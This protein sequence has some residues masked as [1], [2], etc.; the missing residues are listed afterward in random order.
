MHQERLEREVNL[1]RASRKAGKRETRG[2]RRYSITLGWSNGRLGLAPRSRSLESLHDSNIVAESRSS[3]DHRP[4]EPGE[5]KGFKRLLVWQVG[6]DLVTECY[7]LSASF[8]A[9][10]QYGLTR[11]LP[12]SVTLNIAEGWGRDRKSELARGCEIARGSLHEVDAAF[13]VAIRLEY[14]SAETCNEAFRLVN[15]EGVMLHRL[16]ASLKAQR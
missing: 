1:V 7:R 11:Q 5:L 14:L 2:L 13:E 3:Y 12:V 9:E 16:I 15:R 8:P 10:E 6:M 4:S